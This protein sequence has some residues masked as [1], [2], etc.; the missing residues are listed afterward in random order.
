[1]STFRHH[2]DHLPPI[3]LAELDGLENTPT[4]R[5]SRL[6]QSR[7]AL[8]AYVKVSLHGVAGD[9]EL[10]HHAGVA[11][12]E[13]E[14]IERLMSFHDPRSELSKLNRDAAHG[15]VE[16]SIDLMRVLTV[17]LQISELSDGLFDPTVAPQL[18]A[19]GRLPDRGL[20]VDPTA[21]WRDVHLEGNRVR[22]G[23]PLLLDLSGIAKGYAVDRAMAALPSRL[24][25]VVNAGGDLLMRPWLGRSVTICTPDP[26]QRYSLFDIPMRAAAVAT[27]GP[28]FH[29]RRSTLVCPKR[30]QLIGAPFSASVFASTC[31]VADALTKFATLHPKPHSVWG[32]LGA[33]TLITDKSG[34]GLWVGDPSSERLTEHGL[35]ADATLH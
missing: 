23:R 9:H 28:F 22:F 3:S 12:A 19:T 11:F 14:R 29:P 25:A 6:N 13:I 21:S 27:S 33:V 1:M 32:R 31:M 8:G 2:D 35:P 18:I 24:I 30:R 5:V 4:S 15:S 17:A 20:E 26:E 16:V 7:Q 34:T 10:H